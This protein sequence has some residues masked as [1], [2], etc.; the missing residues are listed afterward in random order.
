MQQQKNPNQKPNETKATNQKSVYYLFLISSWSLFTSNW[1]Q[2]ELDGILILFLSG[3]ES[4][5]SA[6]GASAA[7]AGAS[8]AVRVFTALQFQ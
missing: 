4:P 5:A 7:A 3:R 1:F 8:D 6:A 2:H